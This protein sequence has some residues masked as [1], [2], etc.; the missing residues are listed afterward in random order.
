MNE[1]EGEEAMPNIENT[2]K[3]TRPVQEIRLGRV[4]A[5]IWVNRTRE[6]VIYNVT[7]ERSYKDG[8]TWKTSTS[9]GRDD[10]L[11]VAKLAD[12]AHSWMTQSGAT[13]HLSPDFCQG[14]LPDKP[15]P[16]PSPNRRRS[17]G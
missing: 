9:F 15:S 2:P 4:K 7:F 10:L 3:S 1:E 12:Q 6:G 17:D 11:K 13:A 16:T 8:E 5:A 14:R